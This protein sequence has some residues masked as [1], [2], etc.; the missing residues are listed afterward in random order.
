[1]N[2]ATKWAI[3]LL[4]AGPC[5]SATRLWHKAAFKSGMIRMLKKTLG[6]L[7]P[8]KKEGTCY[9]PCSSTYFL[10]WP[11][12]GPAKH[13]WKMFQVS[14]SAPHVLVGEKLIFLSS[15][16]PFRLES[17]FSFLGSFKINRW[18][19]PVKTSSARKPKAFGCIRSRKAVNMYVNV[20]W[21]RKSQN[22][23]GKRSSEIM[24]WDRC[25][26]KACVKP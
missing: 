23:G 18:E 5:L 21:L 10:W 15:K 6:Y 17:V 26:L 24:S 12:T 19:T 3:H 1:M 22:A 7:R 8:P 13:G 14:S 16:L 11:K 4:P 20:R 25:D 9:D 2:S